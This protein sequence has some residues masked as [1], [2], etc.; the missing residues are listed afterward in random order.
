MREIAI[1]RAKSFYTEDG[2]ETIAKSITD[3]KEVSDEEFTLLQRWI[4]HV[5]KGTDD[6]MY[7]LTRIPNDTIPSRIEDCKKA[8]VDFELKLE[9]ERKDRE[10]KKKERE[11][12][13][14]VKTEAEQRKQFEE[15]KEKFGK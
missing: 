9:K 6:V 14:K 5:S 2:H 15:L 11:T 3:W 7:I 13:K 1:I 10:Q 8:A 4:N 12:K